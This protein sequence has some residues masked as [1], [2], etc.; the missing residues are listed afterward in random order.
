VA[1][2]VPVKITK[3]LNNSTTM[4]AREKIRTDLESLEFYNKKI[5]VR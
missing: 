2:G 4:D 1:T 5:D 3:L